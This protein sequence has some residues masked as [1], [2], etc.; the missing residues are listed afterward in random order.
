MR[1][2]VK[3]AVLC[4]V[5]R[6]PNERPLDTVHPGC[7]FFDV[8]GAAAQWAG[9]EVALPCSG[10][11]A[12]CYTRKLAVLMDALLATPSEF[13]Y[14]VEADH[15]LC[16]RPTVVGQL[17]RRYL[18]PNG[19]ELVTTGIGASGWLFTRRWAAAFAAAARGCTKWCACPDCIAAMLPLPRATTRVVLTQHSVASRHG[20][21]RNDKHLPRC[22]QKRVESGMLGFDLFD[23]EAC[24]LQD[25]SPCAT[26]G[27]Q[28]LEGW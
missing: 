8:T 12:V 17:A 14:Y 16:A 2:V 6:Q 26:G 18:G 25:V 19:T 24:A 15:T 13:F 10:Y 21:S 4:A 5:M 28:I 27:Q 7:R 20:L 22:Y 1:T 9:R 3:A 11:T 23:H